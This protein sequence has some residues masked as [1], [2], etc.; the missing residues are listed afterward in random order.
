MV[1][2]IIGGRYSIQIEIG[3]GGMG[4][5]YRGVDNTNQQ[6]VAIKALKSEA[7]SFQL[8][9]RFRREGEALRE[10]N[11]PNIVKM[12]DSVEENDNHYLIMEY[13]SGGDL[14][15]FL[16]NNQLDLELI[17]KI[18]LDLAD[19]LTRAH[20]LNIIHRDLKPAN[21]LIGEDG[22]LRLSDF[23]VAHIG[24]KERVTETDAIVGTIDYLPPEA[25]EGILFD[26]RGDIWAFGVIL[27]ELL[28]GSRPFNGNTL[29]E[30]IQSITT[31]PIPDLESMCP[32][33]PMALVDLIYRM[34]ERELP[35]RIPSARIIGSE[36][37]AIQKGRRTFLPPRQLDS[38]SSINNQFGHNLPAQTTP[39]VGREIELDEIY[40]FLMTSDSRLITIL[41]PGGM[42]KTR[43]ALAVAQRV[44]D[45]FSD[46][47]YFVELAPLTRADDIPIAIA[48]ATKYPMQSDGNDPKQQ[49]L[50]YLRN[51]SLLL[52]L[53]NYEHLPDGFTIVTEILQTASHVQIL[54][55]S[56]QRLNQSGET[57][58]HLSGVDFPKWETPDDALEYAAVQLFFNSAKRARP[59]FDL[60][61]NKL[62]YVARICKIVQGMP[63]GIILAA[64]WLSLLSLEEIMN[65]IESDLDFLTIDAGDLPERQR[66]IRAVMDYSWKQMTDIQQT[67]FMKLSIFRGG[68][69]RHAAK[70]IAEANLRSLMALMNKSLIHRDNYT[71]RYHIHELLRQFT[72][73]K[74]V[75]AGKKDVV[76]DLHSQYFI[77]LLADNEPLIKSREQVSVYRLIDTDFENIR[78]AWHRAVT[79]PK[80]VFRREALET[81]Y[82]VSR[83]DKHINEIKQLYAMILENE[84]ILSQAV[85]RWTKPRYYYYFTPLNESQ[86]AELEECA[87]LAQEENNLAEYGRI[88]FTMAY[89]YGSVPSLVPQSLEVSE[90]IIRTFKAI[91]AN[92]DLALAYRSYFVWLSHHQNESKANQVMEVAYQLSTEVGS[93]DLLAATAAGMGTIYA[94]RYGQYDQA[95][96][97]YL[98]S[99]ESINLISINPPP[100]IANHVFFVYFA[101]RGELEKSTN[102][103][104]QYLE[105]LH[106]NNLVI[107]QSYALIILG[108]I[109]AV[110]QRFEDAERLL[111]QG[112][113]IAKNSQAHINNMLYYHVGMAILRVG[114]E[115]YEEAKK[116]VTYV[117]AFFLPGIR[118]MTIV[119]SICILTHEQQYERAVEY[120]GFVMNH[121][122]TAKGWIAQWNVFQ[123][124][125]ET[126][127]SM[128]GEDTYNEAYERGKQLELADVT[129]ELLRDFK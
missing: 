108:Q 85:I 19:S 51:K 20:K 92:Y 29:I 64:S 87:D 57:L 86:L 106:K 110:E 49:I 103:L 73:Q 55:T 25:F 11:H 117:Q 105:W 99:L 78:I 128:L 23:G 91:D 122:V 40:R 12:L 9:E 14:A 127:K 15:D 77:D 32:D 89:T 83:A 96:K 123:S 41:A 59:D 5:V 102:L 112:Y 129:E 82:V 88:L 113:D 6:I 118:L 31:A 84:S 7:T 17:L 46:G 107:L 65:E 125:T 2:Q 53:D 71:G 43:L 72:E 70:F 120:L 62:D 68:F 101:A 44:L 114:Q 94:N 58:F 24:S 126:L 21:I 111:K 47:V 60:T 56:R 81:L 52:V 34:L 119:T 93:H 38:E 50:D 67:I 97:F 10:L 36:L 37:E 28:S 76:T 33:A 98:Q 121:P 8:I 61:H 63:L 124:T 90:E 35:M 4:T 69:T 42:G 75:E 39:F 1:E 30:V 100:I 116:S 115:K 13:V 95:E 109:G 54:V 45:K 22:V 48:E 80:I 66:S 16:E 27:F 74:L 79:N 18:G 26:E 3:S 104:T